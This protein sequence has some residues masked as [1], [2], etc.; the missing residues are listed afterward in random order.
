MLSKNAEFDKRWKI[1]TPVT[2]IQLISFIYLWTFCLIANQKC[3]ISIVLAGLHQN[4]NKDSCK[5]PD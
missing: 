1:L 2:E 5:I 4:I 3:S